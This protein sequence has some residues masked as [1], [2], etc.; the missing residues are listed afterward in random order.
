MKKL[1]ITILAV[2][3]GNW[4]MAQNI[5]QGEY[6]FDFKKE[7]GDGTQI[8]I[9]TPSDNLFFDLNIPVD[10]LSEGL[11]RLFVRFKDSNN[12]WGQ[13]FNFNVFIKR[14]KVVDVIAGEYFFDTVG[15]FGTGDALNL[16]GQAPITEVL[17]EL[18][19]QNLPDGLHRLFV[20]FLGSDGKWS[21]TMNFNVFI[22]HEKLIVIEEGEYFFDELVEYGEGFPLPVDSMESITTATGFINAPIN[23][24]PG[25]HTMYYRFKDNEGKWSQTFSKLICANVVD[26]KYATDKTSYCFGDTVFFNYSESISNNVVF[27]WDLNNDGNFGDLQTNGEGF[28]YVPEKIVNDT[29]VFK[30][31]ITSPALC[32]STL[33][34]MDS[35]KVEVSP[36]ININGAETDVSCFGEMD[37][38][39]DL[40]VTGGIEPLKCEWNTGDTLKDLT[41]LGSGIYDVV[42]TDSLGCTET[43]TFDI[44]EPPLLNIP[45]AT[46]KDV[47]CL[48]SC[49]GAIDITLIGGTPPY[50]FNWSNGS[51]S[52]DQF[53]LCAGI[54]EV[55]V[56]DA[57]G[58]ETQ[59]TFMVEEPA[60]A[61]SIMLNNIM[62]VTCAG[63]CDGKINITP[64]GATP[65]YTFEWSNGS[66]QEDLVNL[67]PGD[68][69]VTV[70]D[71]L[72]CTANSS[73]TVNDQEE[74]TAMVDTIIHEL[75]GQGDG[76][77]EIS[78]E[79]GTPN[80]TFNWML[81][82]MTISTMEDPANLSEGL[83]T[84]TLTD[85]N[86]CVFSIENILVENMVG[87]FET[88]QMEFVQIF[89][90]PATSH[91]T[92][93]NEPNTTYQIHSATGQLLKSGTIKNTA[94]KINVIG[95]PDGILFIKIKSKDK[96][97]IG[98]FVKNKI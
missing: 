37:G 69:A 9:S 61:L 47:S 24:T 97:K 38:S 8:T 16:S 80:Y 70:T 59:E 64:N 14:E 65:P 42:V 10:T 15:D 3:L 29:S 33:N 87:I 7:Y 62:H 77:I 84:L 44:V 36:E 52:E 91:L 78:V 19:T 18:P 6:F 28:P 60:T 63:T 96:I 88:G 26:G 92:I 48:D 20:R 27:D 56:T 30:Y 41:N 43:D 93:Q 82:N 72:G 11:H 89:P 49:D 51:S 53:N 94:E 5:V 32:P 21:H 17:Q 71:S 50:T 79:G 68:Y 12:K 1:I 83:Y 4:L 2:W 35:L 73:L 40:M 86:G 13:T 85:A 54:Y 98:K 46:F 57:A 55:T 25:E 66:N 39:I 31:V 76:S 58:C 34:K 22:K 95:L 81:G 67:C 45:T 75:D 74:L 90:N 23:L